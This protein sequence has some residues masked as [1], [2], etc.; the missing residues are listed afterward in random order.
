M[1]FMLNGTVTL[2][3]YDGANV[4]IAEEAGIDNNYIFGARVEELA[5][6]MPD[7]DPRRIYAENPD[8]ARV[9]DTLI[10]GTFS[11]GG[12]GSFRE[13][14]YALLDGASWHVPDHY[15][16]LGDLKSYVEAKLKTNADY[17]LDRESFTK[18]CWINMCCSGKFSSDR[19]MADYAQDIWAI[20]PDK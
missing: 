1:Q 12:N 11:D 19:T 13:L 8:I 9:V 3:T 6:I 2:G 20:A 10:D 14:Y 16:L 18:K 7:Y 17:R 15:Y 4:E 5:K